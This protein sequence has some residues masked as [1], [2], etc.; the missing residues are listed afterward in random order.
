MSTLII[1]SE[2]DAI[3]MQDLLER[4]TE[5]PLDALEHLSEQGFDAATDVLEQ[6]RRAKPV[7]AIEPLVVMDPD[8][9]A[10]VLMWRKNDAN[11]PEAVS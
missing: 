4:G 8:E 6:I 7:E 5:V 3:K 9:P 10:L 2:I 11:G 1:P